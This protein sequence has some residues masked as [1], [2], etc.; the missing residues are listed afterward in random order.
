MRSNPTL[1]LQQ[2]S[3]LDTDD[4]RQSHPTDDEHPNAQEIDNS[5]VY[6]T[7]YV[8]DGNI[9]DNYPLTAQYTLGNTGAQI[10]TQSSP[11]PTSIPI[12]PAFSLLTILPLLISVLF[13]AIIFRHR[14]TANQSK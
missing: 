3:V 7:P 10:S 1:D 14:K 2:H 9:T 8:I 6:I 12:V 4:Q 13:I 5:G 11:N